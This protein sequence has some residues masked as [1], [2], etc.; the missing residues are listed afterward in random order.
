M[1]RKSL[2]FEIA[3]VVGTSVIP[4]LYIFGCNRRVEEDSGYRLVMG[5]FANL[6]AIAKD[7][8]T[9]KKCVET[10]FAE[11]KKVDKLMSDYKSDSE[12]SEVNRDAFKRAV[13]VS[14]PTFEV[15]QKSAEFSRLSE[16]AFDITIAPLAEV[17]RSAGEVNSVPT[18]AELA[19]ARSK[20]GY[21]KLILDANEMTVRFAVDGMKLD[22]GGIAKGYAIDRAIEAMQA[23]G[24]VGGMVDVGGDI[25]CF[26]KPPRG[27][28]SW[29]IGLENPAELKGSDQSLS[30]GASTILLILELNNAA[31]ATSGGYRRFVL[32]E[33]KEY[34]H[35]VDRDTAKSAEGLSSVTIISQN[36]INADALATAVSV[37]GPEKGLALIE[38]T[39]QTEAILIT[40][41]PEYQLI[42]TSGAGRYVSD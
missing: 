26:G 17:W 21:E 5:T 22:L 28:K 34:S 7:N 42:K 23:G 2:W 18:E 31:I 12:I 1:N 10:A 3:I 33:G 6:K 8:H 11:L 25:R 36:A 24:A 27:K 15:L 20:V 41:S 14:V 32:V 19:A 4:A 38:K 39:P 30:A 40:P 13:E 29:R 35:I 16:G 37:M 9:A